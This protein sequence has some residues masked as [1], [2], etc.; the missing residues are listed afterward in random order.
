LSPT[1]ELASSLCAIG[2]AAA[3]L[4]NLVTLSHRASADSFAAPEGHRLLAALGLALLLW[5]IVAVSELPGRG[6]LEA[7]FSALSESAM[8][9]AVLACFAFVYRF[10]HPEATISRLLARLLPVTLLVV[11]ALIWAT[12]G[13]TSPKPIVLT[14]LLVYAAAALWTILISRRER[15]SALRGAGLLLLASCA[16]ALISPDWMNTGTLLLATAATGWLGWVVARAEAQRPLEQLR[17]ELRLANRDLRQAVSESASLRTQVAALSQQLQAAG[18]NRSAFL[19]QLGHKLRTPLNSIT[20]Y[21]ELL[22]SGLYG[23]L[24]VKQLDRVGKIRR[25][26]DNLLDMISN[27]LDLNALNAGRL[28]L[29]RT[30][31]AISDVIERVADALEARRR[32]KRLTLI[33]DLDA[34]LPPVSGDEARI[35]QI[36]TQM[37]DNA[38]KFTFEG[39]ITIRSRC[40]RVENGVAAQFASAQFALP[41]TG[42]LSDGNWIIV[43]VG[44]TG[45]GIAPEDQARIFDEFYQIADPRTE[46]YFGTGLGL[47]IAKR[48]AELHEGALWLKSRP[49]Q[50]STITLALRPER[51]TYPFPAPF[52]FSKV[53]WKAL[54]R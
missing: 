29:Y 1:A 23:D 38:V 51:Q 49:G 48:L 39:E 42:W 53:A 8:A 25:N 46:E 45:I 2:I 31:F 41:V 6:A 44:D 47:T 27:M 11:L 19:D 17:E 40:I 54:M 32:E 15:A 7:A 22:Q 20:G 28:E 50:G 21:S 24:N 14:L 9:G 4:F 12:P 36:V 5:G 37:V 34:S 18:Q 35:C 33:R 26:S 10:L 52:R 16:S 3:L 43:E 13:A 30:T